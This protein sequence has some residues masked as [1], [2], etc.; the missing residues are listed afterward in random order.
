MLGRKPIERSSNQC[1]L[2]DFKS[3]RRLSQHDKTPRSSRPGINQK[4][5]DLYLLRGTSTYNPNFNR[6]ANHQA[7]N[8]TVTSGGWLVCYT[9]GV[10]D[11]PGDYNCTPQQL[12]WMLEQ[13]VTSGSRLLHVADAY[14]VVNGNKQ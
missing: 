9:H 14:D 11:N 4:S 10:D 1:E 6:A 7:I 2:V 5:T 12:E 13:A 8:R 3:K